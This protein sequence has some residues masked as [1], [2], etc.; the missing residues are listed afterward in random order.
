MA[1][2]NTVE[3]VIQARDM[4]SAVFRSAASPVQA[5][6]SALSSLSSGPAKAAGTVIDGVG[7]AASGLA[8]PFKAGAS[9][10][11]SFGNSVKTGV[12]QGLNEAKT[13]LTGFGN[14]LTGVLG[15]L[16]GPGVAALFTTAFGGSATAVISGGVSALKDFAAAT[17]LVQRNTGA[18]AEQASGLLAVMGRFGL[19][20]PTAAK[21]LNIFAKQVAGAELSAEELASGA[22]KA[23]GK[24]LEMG[25]SMEDASGKARP[26]N[27]V[28]LDVADRFK[29]MPDGAEKTALAMQLFGREGTKMLPML[30][31]GKQGILDLEATA[32]KMGLTLSQDN[33]DAVKKYGAAT[34][35]MTQA[36][37]GLKLQIGVAVLPLM[38]V[39]AT[40]TA[41][42]AQVVI[43]ALTAAL[44][45]L[46]TFLNTYIVPIFKLWFDTIKILVDS[47]VGPLKTAFGHIT[48][49]ATGAV[50]A[51]SPLQRLFGIVKDAF[52][53]FQQAIT[54]K[55]S[56]NTGISTI[57]RLVGNLGLAFGIAR[58]GL[59][60]FISAITGNWQDNNGISG[61]H[62]A[63]GNIGLAIREALPHIMA[64]A[65]QAITALMDFGNF[66]GANVVPAVINFAKAIGPD[67]I[68]GAQ[69]VW[70]WFQGTALPALQAFGGYIVGT[71]VPAVVSFAQEAG[72]KIGAALQAGWGF[73]QTVV[74]PAIQQF[75]GFVTGTVIPAIQQFAQ[76]IQTNLPPILQAF[77]Q[78]WSQHLQP[79][80][81]AF[82]TWLTGTVI[83]Q[84][85]QMF[86]GIMTLVTTFT[87]WIKEHWDA[88]K[89]VFEV[90]LAAV[91]VIVVNAFQN[92]S[93]IIQDVWPGIQT[94]IQG[95]MD[96]IKGIIDTM[97]ALF[98]GDW[99][100]AWQGI[101][102]SFN[103]TWEI[104]KGIVQIALGLIQAL[105]DNAWRDI[106]TAISI[107]WG[108]IE[109][110]LSGL[111]TG[112]QG[113]A[114]SIWE[115]I[116][117]AIGGAWDWL[118]KK[119]TDGKDALKAAI[120][121]PFDEA[122]T[123]IEGIGNGI[124]SAISVPW[125]AAANGL[126]AWFGGFAGIING[127]A[128]KLHI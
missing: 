108:A 41:Q 119:F 51:V 90:A 95:A 128:D 64:F 11:A 73:L 44:R 83:P 67:L 56:D 117:T 101:K 114:T 21:S 123:V 115:G 1:T 104:I 18:T 50:G 48:D 35:D 62:R 68:A 54:G 24:L 12:T 72:P 5:F 97:T 124:K 126:N 20:T 88:I 75:A 29:A 111:W 55:W 57:H 52:I 45:I 10:A 82:M 86:D 122:K 4:A 81:Q 60:T 110:L 16:K 92:I 127:I 13:Q 116:K 78:F 46:S 107:A 98:S 36:M 42:T 8:A 32:K 71:V 6:G 102:D 33:V 80:I 23:K 38:T 70:G 25:I 53:T 79:L 103:G 61:I 31:Q 7:K 85:K 15:K 26:M 28:L 69:A 112:I 91:A 39:F 105:L 2:T 30:N 76:Y 37:G 125:N 100:A 9:A 121:T 96:V 74:I 118:Q 43:P 106:S 66:I 19:D 93:T 59:I 84:F 22:G 94:V 87:T 58:D 49:G 120:T 17:L 27:D 113:D 40:H 47:I 3:V 63:I 34:K 99:G 77:G 14:T 109:T 89:T 65:G